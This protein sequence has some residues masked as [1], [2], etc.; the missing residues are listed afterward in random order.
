MA[1]NRTR[2]FRRGR[3]SVKRSILY[4]RPTAQNQKYQL[5]RLAGQVSGL[6]STVRK[7]ARYA[8]YSI[9]SANTVGSYA[10]I[11]Y[12]ATGSWTPVFQDA[13]NASETGTV[14]L[15]S[16]SIDHIVQT[17]TEPSVVNFAFYLVR[18]RSATARKLFDDA[19]YDLNNLASGVH[20]TAYSGNL[21]QLN[22]A[23]FKIIQSKRF[24]LGN[25]TE[26]NNADVVQTT[27]L[28]STTKRFSSRHMINAKVKNA[29]GNW[30]ILGANEVPVYARVF[31]LLFSDNSALDIENPLWTTNAIVNVKYA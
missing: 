27:T 31:G 17:W 10:A 4:K 18:F 22:K 2:R 25:K 12:T 11:D 5:A 14:Y 9:S 26:G 16:I 19:G 3:K 24:S 30:K 21:V 15:R 23:Y 28:G 20:F 8:Q 29:S 6:R 1:F 13:T 7:S